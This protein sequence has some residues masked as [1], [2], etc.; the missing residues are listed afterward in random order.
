MYT[1]NISPQIWHD[2][3]MTKNGVYTKIQCSAKTTN[4]SVKNQITKTIILNFN[5]IDHNLILFPFPRKVTTFFRHTQIFRKNCE[6]FTKKQPY[7]QQKSRKNTLFCYTTQ[8]S[9]LFLPHPSRT[10]VVI[11]PRDS[12]EHIPHAKSSCKGINNHFIN[13]ILITHYYA[14]PK[15]I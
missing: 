1:D 6:I 5:E 15:I 11:L 7:F 10:I 13:N 9:P 2:V 8:K 12:Q 3:K 14:K 4:Y